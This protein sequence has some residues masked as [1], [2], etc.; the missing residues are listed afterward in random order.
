MKD[1]QDAGIALLAIEAKIGELLPKDARSILGRKTTLIPAKDKAGIRGLPDG[2]D[3]RQAH[4]AR[5]IASH[6]REVEEVIREAEENEDIPTK[7]AVLNKIAYKRELGGMLRETEDKRAKGG[8]PYQKSTGIT[9]EPV[10]PTL[11]ELGLTKR[12]S[13]EALSIGISPPINVST[14]SS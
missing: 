11:S 4:H 13:S 1:G 7:T 8:Q 5:A 3:F 9:G 6:P 10:E 12:E 2:I 14:T